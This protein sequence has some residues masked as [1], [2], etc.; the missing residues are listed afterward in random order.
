MKNWHRV[1]QVVS[2]LICSTG[3]CVLGEKGCVAVPSP[4]D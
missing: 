2:K 1:S 4:D 3:D